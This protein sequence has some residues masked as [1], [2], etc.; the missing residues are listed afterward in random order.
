MS[1]EIFENNM[2]R[3]IHHEAYRRV[4][5]W[6]MKELP[7]QMRVT[8]TFDPINLI[9]NFKVVE[10]SNRDI[11]YGIAS[12][13]K[14]CLELGARF[15]IKVDEEQLGEKEEATVAAIIQI[16]HNIAV[17]VLENDLGDDGLGPTVP[18]LHS[19]L[20]C[21]YYDWLDMHPR[22]SATINVPTSL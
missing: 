9:V 6:A 19:A 14:D 12:V 5:T 4:L 13:E 21:Y 22:G 7:D 10:K 17:G 15:T 1:R 8:T 16:M 2:N 3:V 18:Q 11:V 20:D